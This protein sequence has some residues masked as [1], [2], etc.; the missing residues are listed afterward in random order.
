MEYVARFE[1]V[2][3]VLCRFD[4][5]IYLGS[6]NPTKDSV[7]VGAM[8]GKNPGSAMPSRLGKLAPLELRGDKMLPTVGNRFTEAFS[9]ADKHV[10]PNAFVR[11]WNLFYVCGNDLNQA[12]KIASQF[13]H[14]PICDS[15]QS[16]V[17]FVWFGWGGS[18]ATLNP[19]KQRFIDRSY[20]PAFFYD[21]TCR[22]IV[23][24]APEQSEFAKH[25]QG[26]PA[27]PIRNYLATVVCR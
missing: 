27:A 13:T 21:H 19:F 5:R 24:R 1:K 4:T 18:N 6:Y 3:G 25:T 12:A 10:P 11:I 20:S 8:V 2:D 7:C 22:N 17:P 26:M 14:P 16:P 9:L 23:S 15:E